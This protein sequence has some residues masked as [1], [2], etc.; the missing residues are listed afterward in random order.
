MDFFILLSSLS[1]ILGST[2]QANYAAGD[3]FHDALARHRVGLSEKA[4]SL[5]LGWCDFSDTMSNNTRPKDRGLVPVTEAQFHA[6]L[7]KF[8]D[9]RI[10]LPTRLDCQTVIGLSSSALSDKK[11][12][13]DNPL[14]R[15]LITNERLGGKEDS[16]SHSVKGAGSLLQAETLADANAAVL[17]LS[18]EK[19]SKTVSMAMADV[20]ANTPLH[21]YGVDSLVAVEL[22]DWFAEVLQAELGVFEILGG[23][24][25]ASVSQLAAKKSNLVQAS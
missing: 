8:C 18:T 22:R 23:A 7:A 15:H 2:G 6:L 4:T 20:D 11:Q 3:T 24:T 25:L 16:R 13:Q 1:G 17:E 12:W 5:D 19:L 9:P 10:G 21:Q 14:V